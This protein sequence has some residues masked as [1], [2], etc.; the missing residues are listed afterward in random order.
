MAQQAVGTRSKADFIQYTRSGGGEIEAPSE[1]PVFAPNIDNKAVAAHAWADARFA[2][3]IMAEHGMFFALLMP[4]ELAPKEHD[5]AIRF[6]RNFTELFNEIDGNGPPD[7]SGVKNFCNKVIEA[8]K[9]FIEYK[10]RLADAQASGK[11]QS[12]VWNLFFD[13]AARGR[14][15][16][17]APRNARKRRVGI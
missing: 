4:P 16:D 2:T 7:G 10:A 11:F 12:L 3:D 1:K 8:M 5:E 9:P 6:N 15:V 17:T 14:A 13:H